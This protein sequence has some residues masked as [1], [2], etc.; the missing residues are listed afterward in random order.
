MINH[1]W[2][3]PLASSSSGL[4]YA[5]YGKWWMV[6]IDEREDTMAIDIVETLW[7]LSM[8]GCQQECGD[9]STVG[10]EETTFLEL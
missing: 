7:D 3:N 6:S 9:V 5:T 1:V 4:I 8:D 2:L 10:S